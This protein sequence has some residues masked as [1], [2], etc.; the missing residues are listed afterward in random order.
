MPGNPITP[1]MTQRGTFVPE[2]G[3]RMVVALPG[4][5]CT[6]E[7]EEATSDDVIVVKLTG[8]VI[9]KAGHGYKA[10]DVIACQRAVNDLNIEEWQ[11]IS[12][13]EVRMREDATRLAR[14]AVENSRRAE[15]PDE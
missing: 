6:C 3:R 14:M 10:G 15:V 13:R 2:V 4:E 9:N 8:I 5:H 12:E 1:I 7:V 11:P